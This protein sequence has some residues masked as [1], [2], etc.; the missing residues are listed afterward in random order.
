MK[1]LIIKRTEERLDLDNTALS[2]HALTS[3]LFTIEAEVEQLD[4]AKAIA[5]YL[6]D[7]YI[8]VPGITIEI[9]RAIT[10]IQ[11]ITQIAR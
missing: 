6:K 7:L 5:D 3:S 9:H 4:D 11:E 1:Y 2:G 8:G 10:S